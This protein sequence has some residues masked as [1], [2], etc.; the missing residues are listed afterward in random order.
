V[1]GKAKAAR[2]DAVRAARA[3]NA[4]SEKDESRRPSE[5]DIV[6][7]KSVHSLPVTTIGTLEV[8]GSHGLTQSELKLVAELKEVS[9]CRSVRLQAV[10]GGGGKLGKL[11]VMF[12]E[13]RFSRVR[14]PSVLRIQS[15][16]ATQAELDGLAKAKLT[17]GEFVPTVRDAAFSK[18]KGVMQ[19]ELC[20]SAHGFPNQVQDFRVAALSSTF[21]EIL[22]GSGVEDAEEKSN[23]ILD[24]VT[25]VGSVI[26]ARCNLG[27]SRVEELNLF[28]LFGGIERQVL[29]A[30]EDNNP[31]E[32]G[33]A[34]HG[35]KR[36]QPGSI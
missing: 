35:R 19:L 34:Y 29:G 24:V 36:T 27:S 32:F 5:E 18:Q 8:V 2:E 14:L 3:L 15:S 10:A 17:F 20:G 7:T 11:L 16:S 21:E 12:P 28:T 13:G 26:M 23:G 4:S 9:H 33:P 6:P 22:A 1:V 25:Q 31:V 30:S